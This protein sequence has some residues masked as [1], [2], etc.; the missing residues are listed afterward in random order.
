MASAAP[1]LPV[2]CTGSVP[3]VAHLSSGPDL[4]P[5]AYPAGPVAGGW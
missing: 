4:H 2:T 5:D 3:F 1:G